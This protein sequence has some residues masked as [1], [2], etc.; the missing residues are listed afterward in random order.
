[1]KRI[2]PAILTCAWAWAALADGNDE[3]IMVDARING[4][5]VRFA[6]DTGAGVSVLIFSK[7]AEKLGLT[8]TPPPPDQKPAPG[9]VANG[10]TSPVNL[11]L[12][13]TQCQTSLGVVDT[14]AYLALGMEGVLGWP[15][16]K[17]NL[18]AIDCLTDQIHF[19]SKLPGRMAGWTKYHILTNLPGAGLTL[20]LP[21]KHDADEIMAI[22]T[23]SFYGVELSPAHWWTWK[24]RQAKPP[25][26]LNA[27]YTPS[28]GL[29][30][31]EEAW[32]KNIV[33]GSLALTDVPV[34]KVDKSYV[35]LNSIPQ[36]SFEATL[37]FAALKR[38]DII[39]DAKNNIAYLRPKKAPPTP[40]D[41]NR[42]GAVFVPPAK[43]SDELVGH[44]IP[45][46]PAFAAGI[47]D[48]DVLLKIGALDCT[49]WRTDPA[50]LPLTR[51]WN[52]PAG[53]RLDLTLSRG[54]KTFE[55]TATLRNILPPDGAAA[56]H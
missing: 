16:I 19:L 52:S 25:Y 15:A 3:R 41:H 28:I 40:Y 11:E 9:Q 47:H 14:P 54:G 55:T 12:G 46:S 39:I 17:G 53:T 43:Q 5:P 38:L 34:T 7:T 6:F 10:T 26:T 2:L 32:A 29:V 20:E 51:F 27:Y 48:G 45:G 18:V 35:G 21:Q 23:G 22:D 37:G 44:V 1:M 56:G 13:G 8:V 50:V 4:Q 31:E 49:R 33:V 42:L 30:V 24:T 36:A